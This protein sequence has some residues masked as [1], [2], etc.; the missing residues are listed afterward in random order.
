MAV[1]VDYLNNMSI[2]DKE[3]FP[4]FNLTYNY[5]S[6]PMSTTINN[7]EEISKILNRNAI[8]TNDLFLKFNLF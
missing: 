7:M 1:L 4:C 3:E 2:N 6:N 5:F 8:G